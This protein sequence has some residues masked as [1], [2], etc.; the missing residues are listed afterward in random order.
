MNLGNAIRLCR[1]QRNLTQAELARRAK[2]SESYLSLL[3]QG[4]RDPTF[5]TLTRIAKGLE[6]PMSLLIF[7]AADSGEL[8][9]LSE[10]V[11]DKLSAAIV[12]LLKVSANESQRNLL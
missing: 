5:S 4:R 3:E 2:I 6:T 12:N 10:E 8:E 1:A 7:L 9:S 11:R